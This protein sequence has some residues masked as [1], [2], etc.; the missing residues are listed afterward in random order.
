[1][2]LRAGVLPSKAV[3]SR[4]SPD[5]NSDC[6]HCGPG[7]KEWLGHILETCPRTH[8]PHIHRHDLLVHKLARM[9]KNMGYN[10]ITEPRIKNGSM[11]CKPD[12]VIWNSERS[13]VL[14]VEV[15]S[16]GYRTPNHGH[17][18]KVEKYSTDE[19]KRYVT[20]LTG[21]QPLITAFSTNWRGIIAPLSASD[22][23][24]L[25]LRRKQLELLSVVTIEQGTVIHR[26]FMKSCSRASTQNRHPKRSHR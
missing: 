3:A 1:M 19:V 25:G 16:D 13:A 9:F 15:S 4:G 10:Y 8:G 14:D 21:H 22:M 23:L 26:H 12:L 7:T 6:D 20:Q 2:S 17:D 11:F 24:L 18:R 5:V